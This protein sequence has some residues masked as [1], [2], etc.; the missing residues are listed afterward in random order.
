M[1]DTVKKLVNLSK[2]FP[3]IQEIYYKR[4][5]L[6]IVVYD[7]N[8]RFLFLKSKKGKLFSLNKEKI[9]ENTYR[10][11]I[12]LPCV[13][14]RTF[15]KNG[16][17]QIGFFDE[18]LL[19]QSGLKRKDSFFRCLIDDTVA[20]N[21]SNL[22]KIYKYGNNQYAYNVSFNLISSDDALMHIELVSYFMKQ[23]EKWFSRK[24]KSVLSSRG[25]RDFIKT[26][27]KNAE[28]L[29]LRLIY[30]VLAKVSR[31][32]N[33]LI[34]YKFTGSL[35]GNLLALHERLK[36][37]KLD[38]KYTVELQ[39]S[40]GGNKKMSVKEYLVFLKKLA[41]A[42][43]VFVDGPVPLLKFIKLTKETKLIQLWHA[44]AG[45]KGAGFSRFGIGSS[46]YPNN[47]SHKQVAYALAPSEPLVEVFKEVIGIEEKAFFVANMPR[48]TGFMGPKHIDRV[49]RSF[50]KARPNLLGKE[51]ILFAP[52]YRGAVSKAYYPYEMLDF[53]RLYDF[54]GDEKV[55]I[56]KMHPNIRKWP[57]LEK[58][59]DR[60]LD[61]SKSKR[62]DINDLLHIAHILITDYSSTYYEYG[63]LKKPMLFYC[64]DK[65]IYENT[66]G[67]YQGVD[68]AAPGKVVNTFDELIDALQNETY[69][70]EKTLRFHEEFFGKYYTSKN[71]TDYVIDKF[72]LPKKSKKPIGKNL[73]NP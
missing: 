36:K 70:F 15:L 64:F 65:Y 53:D 19:K 35:A 16:I 57:N 7:N 17:Y 41:S 28:A 73:F 45:F 60:I 29:V 71:A 48:L 51:I 3:I 63:L 39:R 72:L 5:Y 62:T 44:G 8:E 24:Q 32:E 4:A 11:E 27:F 52:T 42:K 14:N 30:V 49:N 69:D 46:I 68:D 38:K 56:V 9:G 40:D 58:Y 26:F 59:S 43:F 25:V 10:I 23:D 67:V 54:L 18:L 55:M 50:Y 31:Q 2:M 47:L 37:R 1:G 12:F 34:I 61:Y 66:R 6:Y 22:D 20:M 21:I 13:K 33:I